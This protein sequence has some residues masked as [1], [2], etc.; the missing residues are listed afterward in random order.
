VQPIF[1]ILPTLVQNLITS[2]EEILQAAET[3]DGSKKYFPFVIWLP[4][5]L[6][7]K[8]VIR[9]MYGLQCIFWWEN[10]NFCSHFS[11]LRRPILVHWNTI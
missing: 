6:K 4:Q 11:F 10:F 3:E 1:Y 8:F 5:V 9:V 2:D 7:Q